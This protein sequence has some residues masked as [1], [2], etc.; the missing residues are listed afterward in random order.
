MLRWRRGNEVNP[1]GDDKVLSNY[2]SVFRLAEPLVSETQGTHR[3]GFRKN[4]GQPLTYDNL[5][6]SL[7]AFPLGFYHSL[8]SFKT[9][10]LLWPLRKS[11]A[12]FILYPRCSDSNPSNTC[13]KCHIS[14]TPSLAFFTSLTRYPTTATALISTRNSSF[15]KPVITVARAG[16]WSAKYCR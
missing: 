8:L 6:K 5:S 13:N 14:R 11:S 16:K 2:G 10:G 4:G 3:I 15:T 9:S 1:T 12:F 7:H